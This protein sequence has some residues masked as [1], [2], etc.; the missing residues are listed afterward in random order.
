MLND[1]VYDVKP[2]INIMLTNNNLKV[3]LV[4]LN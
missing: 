1:D 4:C 2:Y 3:I